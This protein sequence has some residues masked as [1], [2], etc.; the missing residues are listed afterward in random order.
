MEKLK[1]VFNR[2]QKELPPFGAMNEQI[3]IALRNSLQLKSKLCNLIVAAFTIAFILFNIGG[4]Y[5]Q[6]ALT[7]LG[8]VLF[9]G[10]IQFTSLSDYN[11]V[12]KLLTD[13]EDLEMLNKVTIAAKSS[14]A[15]EQQLKLLG[16][17]DR[18]YLCWYEVFTLLA[19][20]EDDFQNSALQEAK[21]QIAQMVNQSTELVRTTD[22]VRPFELK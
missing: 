3:S 2:R 11:E 16:N 15:V 8:I 9:S 18:D 21:S 20:A 13:C 22:L 10:I 7:C 19:I 12:Q 17:S 1:I 6:V 14:V 5:I 4:F